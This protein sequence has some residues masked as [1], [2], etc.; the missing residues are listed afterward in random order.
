M[1]QIARRVLNRARAMLHSLKER[2]TEEPNARQEVD[3]VSEEMNKLLTLAASNLR[4]PDVTDMFGLSLDKRLEMWKLDKRD[5]IA[6]PEVVLSCIEEIERV[7]GRAP[8][9]GRSNIILQAC[10]RGEQQ[11]IAA[12]DTNRPK[13][14]ITLTANT[15]LELPIM[16]KGQPVLLSGKS[17]Y[18]IWHGDRVMSTSL[19]ICEVK[20]NSFAE[21]LAYMAMVRKIRRHECRIN[22][23][24][25]GCVTDGQEFTF[26]YI[27]E[28]DK[29][30]VWRSQCWDMHLAKDEIWMHLVRITRFASALSEYFG[31]DSYAI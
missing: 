2:L 15:Q 24:I 16:Y 25:Y 9:R 10:V 29:Y 11:R 22:T 17:D 20:D 4:L 27:D 13:K 28:N 6:V 23:K 31:E 1:S 19:V 12:I 3:E 21:C 18:S 30:S 7:T 26:L 8:V 14:P 5:I